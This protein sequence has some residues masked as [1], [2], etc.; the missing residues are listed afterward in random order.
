[1]RY[2]IKDYIVEARHHTCAVCEKSVLQ[3][4]QVVMS[5]VRNRHNMSAQEYRAV[6]GED[7][8]TVRPKTNNAE[9]EERK[10]GGRYCCVVGCNKN[11]G[12]NR[13]GL[14]WF[15]FISST[16]PRNSLC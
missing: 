12:S 8:P 10:P 16:T 15:H 11:E 1:M 9:E 7:I 2:D 14:Y 5:H 6:L 4:L 13:S 3:D